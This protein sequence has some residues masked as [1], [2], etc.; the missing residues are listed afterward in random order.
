MTL[1]SNDLVQPG[2]GAHQVDDY[3]IRSSPLNP[4]AATP[5]TFPTL[6]YSNTGPCEVIPP[7]FGIVRLLLKHD[8]TPEDLTISRLRLCA[9]KS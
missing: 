7:R 1:V 6:R 3:I 5:E 9:A 8:R 4:H 2:I